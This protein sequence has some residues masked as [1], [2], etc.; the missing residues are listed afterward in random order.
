MSNNKKSKIVLQSEL[1]NP[2]MAEFKFLSC[3]YEDAYFPDFLVDKCKIIL[4]NMCVRIEEENPKT[5]D[6]LYKI[7]HL[8]TNQ[9]NELQDD[10]DANDSEIETAARECIA[11]D[12]E[13]IANSYGFEAD[14][15]ELIATREW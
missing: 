13:I 14:I 10:F 8:A 2:K 9:I 12:F 6:D 15:E 7:T 1:S 11:V 4:I 3:M 5:L